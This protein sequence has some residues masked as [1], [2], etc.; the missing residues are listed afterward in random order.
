MPNLAGCD[1]C[2]GGGGFFDEAATARFRGAMDAR[3]LRSS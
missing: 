1:G 3:V 2:E